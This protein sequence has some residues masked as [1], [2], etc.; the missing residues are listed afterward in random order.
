MSVDF[1][2][3]TGFSVTE[4]TELREQIA[5]DWQNAFKEN[6]KPLLNTDPETPQG[7]IIDSQVAAVAQKDSE[8]LYLGQ[9]FDPRTS[10]G[11]FQDALGKIYF[12]TRKP[13]ASDKRVMELYP[14][15]KALDL[16]PQISDILKKWEVCITSELT[17]DEI[18]VLSS[19]L[20][21]LKDKAAIY[22]EGR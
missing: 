21:R 10:E 18:E 12:I 14:T 11:R 4:T 6:D 17:E 22:M 1:N 2:P 20:A 5:E 19:L 9:M 16:L 13:A 3:E 7:Q 8:V 15:Q